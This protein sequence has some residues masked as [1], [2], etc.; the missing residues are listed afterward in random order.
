[1]YDS[2]GYSKTTAWT[3]ASNIRVADSIKLNV[4]RCY[5]GLQLNT[6]ISSNSSRNKMAN[7]GDNPMDAQEYLDAYFPNLALTDELQLNLLYNVKYVS[8]EFF[9]KIA[10]KENAKPTISFGARWN[11]MNLF[12]G[13]PTKPPF[14]PID[15]QEMIKVAVDRSI[16]EEYCFENLNGLVEGAKIQFYKPM[17]RGALY[18]L[19]KISRVN[20]NGTFDVDYDEN[21]EEKALGLDKGL[22]SFSQV[23]NLYTGRDDDKLNIKSALVCLQKGIDCPQPPPAGGNKKHKAT[24]KRNTYK[25]NK[26]TRKY[27]K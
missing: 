6:W 26:R 10:I 24:K 25:K 8:F 11:P 23:D 22:I 12:K 14:H 1:M 5:D 19:G 2:Q 18:K 16:P 13:A 20:A 17:S 7:S 21:G 9:K 4:M 3:L 27:K 15:V